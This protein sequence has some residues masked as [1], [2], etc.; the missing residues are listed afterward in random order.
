MLTW[1]PPR[2]DI[3]GYLLHF[4]SAVGTIHVSS[5]QNSTGVALYRPVQIHVSTV[6]CFLWGKKICEH[7]SLPQEVVLSP[8]AVSYNMADLSASTEYSVKLEALAGPKRSQVISTI[9]TTSLSNLHKITS[10]GQYELRVDLR[11]KG[12]IVYAQYD[13]F[14]VSEPR[15]RYKVHVGGYSGTAG[16]VF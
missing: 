10:G 7:V 1:K 5:Q 11:D 14:S 8:T 3:S 2:A 6:I 15:T 12:E 4:E 13:K 16:R 9:F